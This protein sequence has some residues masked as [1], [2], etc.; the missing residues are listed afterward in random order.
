MN[1]LEKEENLKVIYNTL[2]MAGYQKIKIR[3]L[4]DFDKILGGLLWCIQNSNYF[5]YIENYS[6]DM[7]IGQKIKLS[8]QIVNIL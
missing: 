4:S 1:L 6:D 2:Q 8:E 3:R 7:N 5:I